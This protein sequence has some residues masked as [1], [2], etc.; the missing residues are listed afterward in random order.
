[1]RLLEPPADESDEE[2]DLR[3]G[4]SSI[5]KEACQKIP[6]H[7]RERVLTDIGQASMCW[8]C[9]EH[10]GI[11]DTEKAIEIG[12]ALCRYIVDEINKVKK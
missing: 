6:E 7:I 3:L 11:F 5:S 4:I 2:A 12:D 8:D 10:A 9:P 1:M